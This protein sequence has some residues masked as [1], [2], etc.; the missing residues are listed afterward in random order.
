MENFLR[1]FDI[2][3]QSDRMNEYFAKAEALYAEKGD[4]ILDFERYSIF[5]YMKD[6]ICRIRDEIKTDKDNI[7]YCY[8][9]YE[10]VK[11][12]DRA[13]IK[14][15]SY[16]NKQLKEEKYD[17]LPM[18][19]LL[20]AVP[21][22]VDGLKKRGVPDDIID[23]TL[24]M[25][26]NQTQDFIDLNHRYGINCYVSWLM[27]FVRNEIIRVGRFN[28]EICKY[29]VDYDVFENNG[30]LAVLPKGIVYHKSGQVLGS[31][32]CTDE[33]GSFTGDITETDEYYEGLLIENGL[34]KN[35][36]RRLYKSE[37]KKVMTKGDTVINYHIPTGGKLD[38]ELCEIDIQR[39]KKIIDDC[40]GGIKGFFCLTWIID[41][42]IKEIMGRETN[43]TKFA[44]RF[45]KFPLKSQGH[46]I[47]E[48]VFVCSPDTPLE[49]L[50]EKSGFAKAIKNHLLAGGRIWGAQGVA[51]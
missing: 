8:F 27:K 23:A 21:I 29:D 25:F 33:E 5:T 7:I 44:D 3:T 20:Y 28:F 47:F 51:L 2:H 16:P 32:D 43:L 24:N 46:D 37:W 1:K 14:I 45:E 49:E 40:F 36:T 30:R 15:L 18:F 13:A 11:E 42:Q 17:F 4:D 41:P 34:A 50:P 39:G 10:A 9:L 35:E 26:E 19:S 12:D 48:Y 31:I 6:D 22:M 38:H